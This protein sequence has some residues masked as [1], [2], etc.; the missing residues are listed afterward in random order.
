MSPARKRKKVRN[1]PAP[2]PGFAAAFVDFKIDL[3]GLFVRDAIVAL[4]KHLQICFAANAP[5]IHAVHGHGSGR[6]KTAVR[7]HLKDHDLVDKV[8]PAAYGMGGDG[9]T[10]AELKTGDRYAT[11]KNSHNAAPLPPPDDRR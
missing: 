10:I 1:P 5:I 8:Y 9:V 2:T 3:H 7:D 4:D 11:R 6:L